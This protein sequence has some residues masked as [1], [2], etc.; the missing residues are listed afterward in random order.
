MVEWRDTMEALLAQFWTDLVDGGVPWFRWRYQP[1]MSCLCLQ[2]ERQEML[3]IISIEV[4][5][6]AMENMK[7]KL[8]ESTLT[9][10]G[11]MQISLGGLQVPYKFK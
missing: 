11:V 1:D 2:V 7:D 3:S 5:G 6:E 9:L 8:F 4:V 10:F